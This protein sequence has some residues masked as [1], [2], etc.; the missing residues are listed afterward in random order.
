MSR[1]DYQENEEAESSFRSIAQLARFVITSTLDTKLK[2]K[3]LSKVQWMATEI[4]GKYKCRYASEAAQA[5]IDQGN[6]KDLQH[7][8]VYRKK[9]VTKVLLEMRKLTEILEVI[10]KLRGCVVTVAEHRRLTAADSPETK[11]GWARY[12]KADIKVWDRK[13]R[14]RKSLYPGSVTKSR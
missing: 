12:I 11:N 3:A 7:E 9:D 10:Q 14:R 6:F 8:H 4:H 2:K 13:I 5:Q 1:F